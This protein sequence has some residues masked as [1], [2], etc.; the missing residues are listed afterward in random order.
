MIRQ[1]LHGSGNLDYLDGADWTWKTVGIGRPAPDGDNKSAFIDDSRRLLIMQTSTGKLRAIDL[2]D[3]RSGP[4]TLRTAGDL[5]RVNQSQWHLYPADG[6]W[7]T[8][9]GNGGNDV[10]KIEPPAANPLADTWTVSTVV[11]GGAALPS[12]PAAAI[13]SGAVHNTRFFYVRPLGCFAW[14]AGGSNKVAI[15]KP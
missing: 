5:P 7:Y 4:V 6:C 13:K 1:Y 14:I 9:V 10:Y 8:Y 12:Q 15:L 2:N 3:M 11:I